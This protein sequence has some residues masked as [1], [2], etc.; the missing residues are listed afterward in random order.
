[1]KKLFCKK[2]LW[3]LLLG[4][5]QSVCGNELS[6]EILTNHVGYAPGAAKFCLMIGD[7]PQAFK[8]V[9]TQGGMIVYQ[10]M[11]QAREGF[12]G[13]YL[14]GTFSEVTKEGTYQIE[15]ENKKSTPFKISRSIY[16]NAIKK[17]VTYFSIQRCGPSTT[18]YAAPC[19][20]DDGRRLDTGPG[21][22]VRVRFGWQASGRMLAYWPPRG[23][24]G[25]PA[26]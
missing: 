2:N 6:I 14:V 13:K 19:H 20:I 5:M 1:M 3:L 17:C 11:M 7:K 24:T 22:P 9:N 8:V 21:W 23:L 16:D 4:I 10:G 18:G 25:A 12:F 15:V 26:L